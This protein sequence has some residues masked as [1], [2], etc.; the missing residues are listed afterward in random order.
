VRATERG[1]GRHPFSLDSLLLDRGRHVRERLKE[2]G[3]DLSGLEV[4][5]DGYRAA[6]DSS[7]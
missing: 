4:G 2:Q 5:Q 6:L 1:V 3:K 7:G